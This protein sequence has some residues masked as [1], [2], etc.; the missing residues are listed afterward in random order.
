MEFSARLTVREFLY[1][2]LESFTGIPSNVP[3]HVI[4]PSFSSPSPIDIQHPTRVRCN[5]R[6]NPH[7]I[8]RESI[9][10]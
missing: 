10:Q 8:G 2:A 7:A 9:G 4:A 5:V 3:R 6:D 1:I